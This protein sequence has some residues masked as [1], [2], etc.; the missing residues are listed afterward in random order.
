M[1]I[2]KETS[3][4]FDS[5]GTHIF[6]VWATQLTFSFRLNCASKIVRMSANKVVIAASTTSSTPVPVGLAAIAASNQQQA[7]VVESVKKMARKDKE[8]LWELDSQVKG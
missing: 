2:D 5:E 6:F 8:Y 7:P 3:N 1:Y 4:R